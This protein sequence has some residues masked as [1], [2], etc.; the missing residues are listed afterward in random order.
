V[1]SFPDKTFKGN[2]NYIQPV[3]NLNRLFE[4]RIYIDNRDLQLLEGMYARAQVV[5]NRIP[6][7]VRIPVDALLEQ[8]RTNESN[9][10]VRVD[11]QD[12]AEI[13]RVKIG[14]T[15]N[16]HAQVLDGI[17]P[18]DRVVVEGKEVLS[19][20]QPLAVT[21]RPTTRDVRLSGTEMKISESA[22]F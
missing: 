8:I 1:D 5:V 7:V 13:V 18:G 9:A 3:T 15:D 19:T 22:G 4:A 16:V 17:K 12:R 11:N 14:A 2:I 21:L 10:V 6:D 20:G